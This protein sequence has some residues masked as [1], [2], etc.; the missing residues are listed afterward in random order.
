MPG[1]Y[2]TD[3]TT[4]W[5]PHGD[6]G[7]VA[8]APAPA[9]PSGGP[10]SILNPPPPV[11]TQNVLTGPVGATQLEIDIATGGT[12][13]PTESFVDYEG[14]M[15]NEA[16]E[17][18]RAEQG[19]EYPS[20]MDTENYGDTY[21]V[22]NPYYSTGHIATSQLLPEQK[23]LT[24][25]SKFMLANV[26]ADEISKNPKY[27]KAFKAQHPLGKIIAVDSKGNPILDSSG[28]PIYTTFGKKVVDKVYES[29]DPENPIDI[30]QPGAFEE[31]FASYE[32][33]DKYERDFWRE[34]EARRAEEK[35]EQRRYGRRY[36]GGQRDRNLA[37]LQFLRGGS[38]IKNLEKSPFMAGMKAAYQDAPETLSEGLFSKII[39]GGAFDPK[40]MKRLVTSWGSGYTNPRYANVAA[41]GGIM[42]AWNDMRR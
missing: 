38:P 26:I 13:Q 42:S 34:E 37:L 25:P 2:G 20:M 22:D 23:P 9:Q 29:Y 36:G 30:T 11:Q 24:K 8:P 28:N 39:P 35:G 31:H 6:T 27:G 5:G 32:E 41:R 33:L 17:A 4:P 19:F 16:R 10:P 18:L 21:N 15:S 12:Q 7:Y 40:A 3:E 1:G 14:A